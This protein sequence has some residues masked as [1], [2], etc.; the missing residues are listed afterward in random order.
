VFAA[1]ENRLHP[2]AALDPQHTD[3]IIVKIFI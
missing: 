2:G 3:I 1:R